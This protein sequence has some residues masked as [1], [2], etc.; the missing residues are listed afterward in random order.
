MRH[1]ILA[2]LLAAGAIPAVA[3]Q[4]AE[5]QGAAPPTPACALLTVAEV[6]SITG[7][8]N[9]PTRM[10]GDPE[11]QGAGGGSSCQYGGYNMDPEPD[12]PLLSLILIKGKN[13]TERSRGFPLPPGCRRE[14]V[15]GVGQDAFFETCPDPNPIRTPRFYVKAGTNDLMV[16]IDII[17]PAT[18]ESMRQIVIAIAK[19]AVQKL[20]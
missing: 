3:V 7:N 17:S 13:H 11:G 8:K 1:R 5:G 19:A 18:P 2:L 12:P 16:Q 20:R 14:T 10:N 6:R 4:S 15:P 9:Y